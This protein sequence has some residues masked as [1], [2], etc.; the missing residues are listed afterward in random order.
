MLQL[1]LCPASNSSFAAF[2]IW[3]FKNLQI[4]V[5]VYAHASVC[6]QYMHVEG[7]REE[8]NTK[9]EKNAVDHEYET[10]N[11]ILKVFWNL[12]RYQS[13]GQKIKFKNT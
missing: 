13:L 7:E 11:T 12:V 10:L 3:C 8:I 5:C 6:V 4:C 2:K 1:V 9:E